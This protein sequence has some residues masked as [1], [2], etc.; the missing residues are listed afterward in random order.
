MSNPALENAI[1]TL[2]AK[3]G[4][5]SE[6]TDWLKSLKIGLT[7]LPM[8]PWTNSGFILTQSVLK[9]DPLVRQLLMVS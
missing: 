5:P 8:Q 7:A 3:I 2:N 9:R 1:T 6:P 4:Q